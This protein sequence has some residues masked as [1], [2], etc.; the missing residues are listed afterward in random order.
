MS[1]TATLITTAM[2]ARPLLILGLAL[3]GQASTWAISPDLTR[4]ATPLPT[5]VVPEQPI[6]CCESIEQDLAPIT[7]PTPLLMPV[8]LAIVIDDIGNSYRKGLDAIALPGHITYAVMPHR[9]HSKTLAERAARL[10]KEV[11]LHAPMATQNGRVLGA[12]ALTPDLDEFTFK[13][14]LRFAIDSIPYVSG[15]NNHMGSLLTTQHTPM[16]W[17]MDVLQEKHLFFVDSRTHAQS[18]AYATALSA[19]VA[20]A[21][22]DVFLDHEINIDRIHQQFKRALAIAEQYGSAIAIGHPHTETLA[23][24][25][26]VLPQLDHSR[27]QLHYVSDLIKLGIKSRPDSARETRPIQSPTLDALVAKLLPP[28]T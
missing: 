6:M 21:N 5:Q 2:K 26:H 13:A 14:K 9:K 18:V 15:I 7:P 12:G 1:K 20:T 28:T 11:I 25:N 16:Q 10:G 23:Y 24:L 3:L 27:V 4:D 8:K 22:R 19:G 17:V